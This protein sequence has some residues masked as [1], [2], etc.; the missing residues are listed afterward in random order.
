MIKHIDLSKYRKKIARVLLILA[1]VVFCTANTVHFFDFHN[2]EIYASISKNYEFSSNKIEKKSPYLNLKSAVLIDIENQNIVYSKNSEIQRP[3]ASI[4]KLIA[5]MVI[6]DKGMDLNLTTTISKSDAR[7]SSRS[8][9]PV[10]SELTLD[11][12]M[13]AGLLNSD[14]RAIRA[15][16]RATSGTV[17]A[18]TAEMNLK[19]KRLGLKKTHFMEPTGLSSGNVSTAVEVAKIL[20]YVMEYDYIVKVTSTKKKKV[21]ILNKK[22]KYLQMANTNLLVQSPYKVLTGK[23]GYIRASDYCLATMVKN[24]D[25]KK[26]AAVI[27][28]VPGDKLRFREARKLLNWGF[29]NI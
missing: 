25:G 5:A 28:G 7:R 26:L 2:S 21:R 11:D 9:L 16:A 1:F 13:Y 3:I 27:L 10:G 24:K 19:A 23:T 4:S 14:N 8:R 12:L 6:I 15:L 20:Y 29:K 22:N 17:E 18:F